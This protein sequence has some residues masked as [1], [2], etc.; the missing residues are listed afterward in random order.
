MSESVSLNPGEQPGGCQCG[1]I[2]YAAP[3]VPLA[4]YV[5][6][7]TECRKQTSS[8]FGIS[9]TVARSA[10]RLLQGTPHWWSRN[11][12]SGH[13][14]ECAFCPVC[15]S[16]LW[17]QSSGHPDRLNIKGGSLDAPV[18]LGNAVHIWVSSKLPG[19]DIPS[20]AISFSHEP[21]HGT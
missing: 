3:K 14:L 18:D 20:G 5:C 16:R 13:T 8:A 19:V 17:H 21:D 1:S 7:C 2:R 4:L 6:H 15:G 11:T 9:F 10:H 12:A